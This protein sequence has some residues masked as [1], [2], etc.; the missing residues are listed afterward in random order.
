[1]Y[2]PRHMC[3]VHVKL[4]ASQKY[5]RKFNVNYK[6]FFDNPKWNVS[7]F[8][9]FIYLKYTQWQ[10]T[11]SYDNS[12]AMYKF[13]KTLHAGGIRTQ[14]LLFCTWWPL[15]QAA[16]ACF[17]SFFGLRFRGYSHANANANAERLLLIV[18]LKLIFSGKNFT[19]KWSADH[20]EFDAILKMLIPTE[21]VFNPTPSKLSWA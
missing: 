18:N 20:A 10:C 13:L 3:Q 6:I 19:P 7:V 16:R 8:K 2:I 12:T 11:L 21:N 1:M 9:A 15:Y 17:S 4:S 14:N 5:A